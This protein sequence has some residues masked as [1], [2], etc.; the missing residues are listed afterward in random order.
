MEELH[1]DTFE[2]EEIANEVVK[3]LKNK[4]VKS[5]KLN[6]FDLEVD[7]EINKM[8]PI[9]ELYEEMMELYDVHEEYFYFTEEGIQF[10]CSDSEWVFKSK[11]KSLLEP[12]L[13]Y[14]E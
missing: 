12:F 4:N 2:M 10:E 5:I 8:V 3:F 13:K 14:S 11:D 6:Y 1:I 9:E 7:D